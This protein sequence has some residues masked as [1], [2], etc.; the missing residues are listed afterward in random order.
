MGFLDK[1]KRMAGKAEDLV[2]EHDDKILDGIDK[3]AD[4]ADDK[5]KG[6]HSDKIDKGAASAKEQVR[7]LAK[8]DDKKA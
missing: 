7:K 1:L 5:T 2:E 6:K 8:E 3:A 4:F